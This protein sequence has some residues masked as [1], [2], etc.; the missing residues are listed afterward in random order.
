MRALHRECIDEKGL[1]RHRLVYAVQ[2][3]D[4]VVG[5]AGDQVPARLAHERKP[6]RVL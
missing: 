4:G 6:A 2:V 1:V 3:V 5:Y